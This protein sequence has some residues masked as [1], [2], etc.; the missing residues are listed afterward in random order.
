M[1]KGWNQVQPL[2]VHVFV[3]TLE[4]DNLSKILLEDDLAITTYPH[5]TLLLAHLLGAHHD[6]E[7]W[8]KARKAR[9]KALQVIQSTDVP[10]SIDDDEYNFSCFSKVKLRIR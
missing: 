10:D 2:A 7:S 4:L 8:I 5:E 6:E 3:Q 9:K 1:A